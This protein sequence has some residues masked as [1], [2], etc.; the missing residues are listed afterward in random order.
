MFH[1]PASNKQRS[2]AGRNNRMAEHGPS[3]L[4]SSR[5]QSSVE[6]LQSTYGNQAVLRMLSNSGAAPPV[7]NSLSAPAVQLKP[8]EPEKPKKPK[9][10]P[11]GWEEGSASTWRCGESGMGTTCERCGV[12]LDSWPKS[13]SC[14]RTSKSGTPRS[15]LCKEVTGKVGTKVAAVLD[16]KCGGKKQVMNRAT[17]DIETVTI[18]DNGPHEPTHRERIIDLHKDVFGS[19]IFDV[20]VSPY[21]G[22]TDDRLEV[23]WDGFGGVPPETKPKPKPKPKEKP[24]KPKGEKPKA[25]KTEMTD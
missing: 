5:I 3:P 13:D 6:H 9:D 8:D 21:Q 22:E 19:G 25:E 10:C 17:G 24:A 20:C 4:P 11:K 15:C 2:L 16:T 14:R 12:E 7:I 23:C 1:A 18:T